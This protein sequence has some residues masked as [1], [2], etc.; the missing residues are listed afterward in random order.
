MFADRLVRRDETARPA[1]VAALRR[2]FPA[3]GPVHV[4]RTEAP[5]AVGGAGD[6]RAVFDRVW[7]EPHAR[8][9]GTFRAAG[10][11]PPPS[12]VLSERSIATCSSA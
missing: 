8:R 1:R 9:E 5:A 6:G 10:L 4:E 3:R 7:C 11:I 12:S 2:I